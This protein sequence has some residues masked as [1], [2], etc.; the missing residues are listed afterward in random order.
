MKL[1]KFLYNWTSI[2]FKRQQNQIFKSNKTNRF[3]ETQ[4]H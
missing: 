4:I 1:I 3:L 2:K